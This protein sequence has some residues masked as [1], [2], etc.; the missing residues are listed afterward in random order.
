MSETTNEPI[1]AS[2]LIAAL[3][4][5]LSTG[6]QLPVLQYLGK[7]PEESNPEDRIREAIRVLRS[8]GQLPVLANLELAG[9]I[10]D[11]NLEEWMTAENQPEMSQVIMATI[12]KTVSL[13]V[14]GDGQHAGVQPT[15]GGA[16]AD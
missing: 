14:D 7:P 1:D 10:K 9:Q 8:G 16:D 13:L 12:A 4:H 2:T 11:V 3:Q 6:Q 5:V 15:T